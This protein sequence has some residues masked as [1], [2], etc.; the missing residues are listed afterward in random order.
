LSQRLARLEELL[1]REFANLLQREVRDP[2]LRNVV[3]TRVEL[4]PDLR[5]AKVFVSVLNEEMQR[6]EAI[7]ALERA[8][9]FLRRELAHRLNLRVTPE[10]QFLLDRGAEHSQRIATILEELQRQS[11]SDREGGETQ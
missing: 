8:E 1:L 4:S 2:R 7:R 5:H 9:G 11:R 10:L 6:Q 3:P